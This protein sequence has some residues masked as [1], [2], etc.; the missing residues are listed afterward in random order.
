MNEHF[1]GKEEIN[2]QNIYEN[3]LHFIIDQIGQI[4]EL[5]NIIFH[6]IL[7]YLFVCLILPPPS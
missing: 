4:K 7:Y 5:E 6:F 1:T 3:I 2:G